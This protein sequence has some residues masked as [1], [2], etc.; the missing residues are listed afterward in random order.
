M[1]TAMSGSRTLGKT[2]QRLIECDLIFDPEFMNS[3]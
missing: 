2:Y 1:M 3:K